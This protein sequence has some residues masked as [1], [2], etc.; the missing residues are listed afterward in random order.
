MTLSKNNIGLN[1]KTLYNSSP[2]KRITHFLIFFQ[3]LIANYC[4]EYL[5]LRKI[6]V[7][8]PNSKT[9][10]HSSPLKRKT[11]FLIFLAIFEI[12]LS[13]RILIS[14]KNPFAQHFIYIKS[15]IWLH[16]HPLLKISTNPNVPL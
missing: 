7:P 16:S 11:H 8:N 14:E 9:L 3:I 1:S 5:F 6:L 13:S 4:P 15:L 12:H 10:S 2:L